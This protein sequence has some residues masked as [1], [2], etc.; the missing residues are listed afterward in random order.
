MLEIQVRR[1]CSKPEPQDQGSCWICAE[2]G[3]WWQTPGEES[4]SYVCEW[5]PAHEVLEKAHIE[6]IKAVKQ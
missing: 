2:C 6:G 3:E 1:P 4:H 5:L